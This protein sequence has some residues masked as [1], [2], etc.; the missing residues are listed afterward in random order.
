MKMKLFEFKKIIRALINEAFNITKDELDNLIKLLDME[1]NFEGIALFLDENEQRKLAQEIAN[2]VKKDEG[3]LDVIFRK[4]YLPVNLHDEFNILIKNIKETISA[5]PHD[6]RL[7][8]APSSDFVASAEFVKANK[9][10]FP[11][12]FNN[13]TKEVRGAVE[14]LIPSVNPESGKKVFRRMRVM[15]VIGFHAWNTSTKNWDWKPVKKPGVT[16]K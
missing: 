4:F 3:R 8:S 1:N 11:G 5:K 12:H 7:W 9:P 15:K 6:E 2:N 14:V 13:Q 16:G 10:K